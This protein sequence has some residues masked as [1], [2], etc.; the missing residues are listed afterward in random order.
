MK[1]VLPHYVLLGFLV[2]SLVFLGLL[3]LDVEQNALYALLFKLVS[4][5]IFLYVV[6]MF[7]PVLREKIVEFSEKCFA[8]IIASQK[9]FSFFNGLVILF[10]IVLAPFVLLAAY[11]VWVYFSR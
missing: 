11:F 10:F 8:V 3:Y 6:A 4:G 1:K 7:I 9:F 2:C 5:L